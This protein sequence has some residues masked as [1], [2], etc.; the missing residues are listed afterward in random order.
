MRITATNYNPFTIENIKDKQ[1]II[2]MLKFE[3]TIIH[4]ELG[5]SIFNDDSYEHFTT[6][7]AMI[8]IHRYVL[9]HFGF[10]NKE[11]DITI[12]RKIFSNY[13]KSP[14]D[15]DNDVISAVT[16]MRENK[17][18]YYKDPVYNIGD[19]FEDTNIYD[20][21]GKKINIYDKINKDSNYTLIGAFSNS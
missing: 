4:G 9:N 21:D 6:L 14:T 16:Y 11:E 1:L 13:Y 7:E 20:I 8:C 12:Y 2:T 17:C 10:S 5:E 15:Y 3:D 19:K 18:I